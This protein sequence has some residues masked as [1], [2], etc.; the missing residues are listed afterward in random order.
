V[1]SLQEVWQDDR[2]QNTAEWLLE[3]LAGQWSWCFGG[4]AAPAGFD[5]DPSLRSGAAILSRW[6]IDDHELFSLP[7]ADPTTGNPWDAVE[8]ELL[9]AHTAGID[10]FTAHL[11]PMLRRGSI[12]RQQVRFI[13][14]TVAA[15]RDPESSVPPILCGDFNAEPDS[16]EVRFLSGLTAIDGRDAT[17]GS[18]ATWPR[19]AATGSRRTG[20]ACSR[21]RWHSTS[22]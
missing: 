22:R 2:H 3:R 20:A 13:D 19:H 9:A 15:W 11:S 16:D 1:V 4:F 8:M 7:G 5:A 6:P 17:P 21:R 14:E 12:R 10:V 18:P